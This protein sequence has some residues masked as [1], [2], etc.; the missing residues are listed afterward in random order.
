MC[1]YKSEKFGRSLLSLVMQSAKHFV[2]FFRWSDKRSFSIFD[3]VKTI[4]HEVTKRASVWGGKI[5]WRFK[6]LAEEKIRHNIGIKRS[7]ILRQTTKPNLDGEVCKTSE[8]L[9]RC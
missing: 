9:N 1:P 8:S 2:V 4:C 5:D 7:K 3:K 6:F